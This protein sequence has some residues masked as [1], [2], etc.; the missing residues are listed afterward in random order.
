MECQSN[1][2]IITSQDDADALSLCNANSPNT[3]SGVGIAGDITISS[4]FR[5]TR[6]RLSGY[7]S[8]KGL[9]SCEN[10]AVLQGLFMDSKSM[11]GLDKSSSWSLT[12]RNLSSL[13]ILEIPQL[14]SEN[15]NWFLEDLPELESI[16][17]H[18]LPST[19]NFQISNAPKLR[20][21]QFMSDALRPQHNLEISNVGLTSLDP[22]FH[23]PAPAKN[24]TIHGIPNIRNLTYSYISAEKV[25]IHGNNNLSLEFSYISGLGREI[26][27]DSMILTGLR[28]LVRNN[29]QSVDRPGLSYINFGILNL[30]RNSFTTL[31]LGIDA[32]NSLYLEDNPNL[33]NITFHQIWPFYNWSEIVIKGN[34]NLQLESSTQPTGSAGP[35]YAFIWPLYDVQTMIFEGPFPNSFL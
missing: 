26:K 11:S 31:D 7:D 18:S 23:R 28:S 16:N 33:R 17:L 5:Q 22:I 12:L 25:E 13:T 3:P 15:G 10:S 2:H 27:A 4:A 6:L 1:S 19:N 14:G 21:F 9:L 29:N 32:I 20:D 35:N 30:T 8:V 34:P 24:I